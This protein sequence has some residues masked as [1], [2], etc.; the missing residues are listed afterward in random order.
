[1][2][3]TGGADQLLRDMDAG[4]QAAA[5]TLPPRARGM[6][7][8]FEVSPAPYAAG[9]GS[10]IGE[11]M[12]SLGLV[13]IIGPGSAPFPLINP[14]AVVRAAPQLIIAS[15]ASLDGM[16]RRPGWAALAALR[17]GRVCAFDGAERDILVRPGPRMAEAAG[18]L[19]RCAAAH[20]PPEPAAIQP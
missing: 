18:L 6:R 20:L 2:L 7:V 9:Q 19:A 8:Y 3:Q 15:R 11:L 14:E 1:L 5:Q 17:E 4:V 16:A 12:R 13:N 10:F